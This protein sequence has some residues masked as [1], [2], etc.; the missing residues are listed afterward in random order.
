[1]FYNTRSLQ[2]L[3]TVAAKLAVPIC[4]IRSFLFLIIDFIATY[5]SCYA[6]IAAK[7]IFAESFKRL[8][9]LVL[10]DPHFLAF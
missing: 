8:K 10:F 6:V 1:M 7:A 9:N 2:A 4:G 3:H 5:G